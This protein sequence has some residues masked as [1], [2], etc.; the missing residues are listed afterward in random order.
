MK[1][2]EKFQTGSVN[3]V[4]LHTPGHTPESSSFLL[5]DGDGKEFCVFTGDTVFLGDV[6]RPDLAVSGTISKEDLASMLFDSIQKMKKF[7]DNLRIYPGHGSGSA[8]GK[9][10]GAGNFCTIGAQK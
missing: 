1:D 6:G 8:C 2:G 9:S 5:V 4:V 3:T 10:I 7:D